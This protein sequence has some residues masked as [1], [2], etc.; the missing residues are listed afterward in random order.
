MDLAVAFMVMPERLLIVS[1]SID[2]SEQGILFP[3]Q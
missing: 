3:D 2:K 1:G